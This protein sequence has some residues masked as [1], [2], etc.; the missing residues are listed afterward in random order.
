[1]DS[2]PNY[3]IEIENWFLTPC[4]PCRSHQGRGTK[5]TMKMKINKEEGEWGGGWKNACS[6]V[7]EYYMVTDVYI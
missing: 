2:Q 6:S 5:K 1:M 7:S 3:E 4:Q